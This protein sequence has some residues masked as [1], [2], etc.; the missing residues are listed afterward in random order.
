VLEKVLDIIEPTDDEKEGSLEM[1]DALF[2]LE[3][4]QFDALFSVAIRG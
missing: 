4:D 2:G 3:P 1:L